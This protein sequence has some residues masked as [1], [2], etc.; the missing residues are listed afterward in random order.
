[1]KDEFG[2]LTHQLELIPS[3]E[4]DRV[5]QHFFAE[6]RKQLK[7]WR[8]RA[9][10]SANNA[11]CLRSLLARKRLLSQHAWPMLQLMGGSLELQIE[12]LLVNAY[13]VVQNYYIVD[14]IDVISSNLL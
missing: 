5:L 11:C 4:L 6:L 1:M 14:T 8:V 7:W 2:Q 12:L 9:R 10:K 3:E 13:S